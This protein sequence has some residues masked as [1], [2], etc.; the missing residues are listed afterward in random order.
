MSLSWQC[1]T[2]DVKTEKCVKGWVSAVWIQMKLWSFMVSHSHVPANET[3]YSASIGRRQQCN[4]A[5]CQS[6]QDM[7]VQAAAYM[8]V[9]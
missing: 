7:S 8:F 6:A 2:A 5:T 4:T 1:R 9:I 3:K